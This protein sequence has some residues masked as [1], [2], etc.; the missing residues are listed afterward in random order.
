MGSSAIIEQSTD[1][2]E[3]AAKIG[4]QE[5]GKRLAVAPSAV[6]KWVNEGHCRPAYNMAARLI[7]RESEKPSADMLYFVKV[8]HTD[9]ETFERI[10]NGLGLKFRSFAE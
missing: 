4:L 10:I 9:R 5:T 7:L 8:P 6:S 3:L 2:Q 1:V